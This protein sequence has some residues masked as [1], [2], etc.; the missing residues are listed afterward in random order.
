[1]AATN[2]QKTPFLRT[3]NDIARRGG[4]NSNASLGKVLPCTV[5]KVMGSIVTV[6]FQVNA[7]VQTIPPATM[8]VM[9]PEYIRYPIQ[10]GCKGMAV[11]ADAFLGQMSGLGTGTATLAQPPN[12]SALVFMPFGN[13]DFFAVDPNALVLYGPNGVVLRD[14]ANMAN[15]TLTPNQISMSAGGHTIVINSTGVVIDG[16]IFLTHTHGGVM[17]GGSNTTGVT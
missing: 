2:A 4:A 17:T 16:K 10:V 5:S 15:L 13:V 12:L 11:A 8:P 3:L 7:G 6:N 9:G 1:M 14:S